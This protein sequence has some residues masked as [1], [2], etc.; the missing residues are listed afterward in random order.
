VLV[1]DDDLSVG[2][3]MYRAD[4]S[5]EIVEAQDVGQALELAGSE[6]FDAIVCERAMPDGD[7][8]SFVRLARAV[9][10]TADVPIIVL[11][12]RYDA[13]ARDEV[14]N[15]GADAY[16]P[17][18]VRPEALLA[19]L[20][21]AIERRQPRH[22]AAVP[23]AAVERPVSGAFVDPSRGRHADIAQ[24]RT[25]RD[26][27]NNRAR[28]ALA[29]ADGA[30]ARLV[31]ARAEREELAKQL[32]EVIAERD[33]LSSRVD[34]LV[35]ALAKARAE[36]TDSRVAAAERES[37]IAELQLLVADLEREV[38]DAKQTIDLRDGAEHGTTKAHGPIA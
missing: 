38:N 4:T 1:V 31:Q 27:A 7:A 3:A 30:E 34:D 9:S 8:L 32:N 15:A 29:A 6:R 19:G 2:M 13:R 14:I 23:S 33:S 18:P 5:N 21:S 26:A 22:L 11:A 37:T 12:A 17:K 36:L 20:A 10:T 25:S 35:A 24:L 16:L 28:R